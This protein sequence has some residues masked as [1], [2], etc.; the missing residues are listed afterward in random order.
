MPTPKTLQ[1]IENE[2]KDLQTKIVVDEE[3]LY[4][5]K[6]LF[7]LLFSQ[8]DNKKNNLTPTQ[9]QQLDNLNQEYKSLEL[10]IENYRKNLEDLLLE[11]A[12]LI[13]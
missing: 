3:K 10:T 12:K 6:R 7:G 5:V 1:D 11:K 2:I 4:E 9:R 8:I 13:P